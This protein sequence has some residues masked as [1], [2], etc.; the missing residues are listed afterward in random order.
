[1]GVTTKYT[2]NEMFLLKTYEKWHC[3]YRAQE[4]SQV[5]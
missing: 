1:M 4:K 3:N 5:W 2:R